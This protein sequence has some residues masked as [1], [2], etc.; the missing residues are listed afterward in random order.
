VSYIVI[1]ED[2]IMRKVMVI[3]CFIA[4]FLLLMIPNVNSIEYQNQKNIITSEIEIM[5]YSSFVKMVKQIPKD[6]LRALL[7]DTVQNLSD[8]PAICNLL[9]LIFILFSFTI[10]RVLLF[11][12]LIYVYA[13][14][15]ECEWAIIIKP[16]LTTNTCNCN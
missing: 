7:K 15:I 10:F 3:G 5:D 13:Y 12:F 4:G 9:F 6:E 14:L 1:V 11:A 8:E 16:S 2:S